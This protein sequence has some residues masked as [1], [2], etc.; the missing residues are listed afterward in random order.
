MISLLNSL[1]TYIIPLVIIRRI[2]ETPLSSAFAIRLILY[3]AHSYYCVVLL[4][5]FLSLKSRYKFVIIRSSS[6]QS[7]HFT[8]IYDY[9]AP[10]A[11]IF[12]PPKVPGV[13]NGP[14]L[15]LARHTQCCDAA[16]R[17]RYLL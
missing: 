2:K 6:G 12:F 9:R 7:P 13:A 10:A 16:R 8:N 1:A 4:S 3:F 11:N 5:V 14:E 15:T 17:G